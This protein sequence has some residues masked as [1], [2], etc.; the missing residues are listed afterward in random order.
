MTGEREH[1]LRTPIGRR[2]RD[3][4]DSSG[5]PQPGGPGHHERG[6]RRRLGGLGPGAVKIAYLTKHLDNPWFVSETG[7]AEELAGELGVDLTV[8][9]LQFD[10]NL[11]LTAMDTVISAGTQGIII[12]VP[13]QQI[14]PAV[15]EKA[16]AAGIPLIAVDDEIKDADGN[17]APF[18]GFQAVRVGEQVG[19]SRRAVQGEGL[20]AA[21]TRDRVDRDADPDG[22]HG[23]D[24]R[25]HR[26]IHRRRCRTSP[27]RTS[28]ISRSRP[29][30]SWNRHR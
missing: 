6:H 12:V 9:D 11:A 26:D 14:G 15:M 27:P 30:R 3:Q 29:E 2:N 4:H 24:E 23:P 10:A 19:S 20:D 25:R 5:G 1:V 18:V 7:G 22:V 17:P 8:Q 16:A 28:S 13:E 21:D